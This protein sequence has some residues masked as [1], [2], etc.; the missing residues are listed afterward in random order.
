MINALFAQ[1]LKLNI[2]IGVGAIFTPVGYLIFAFS[3]D[4][5][6]AATGFL[7]ITFALSFANI[8]FLTFYQNNVPVEIMG[9]FSS[10]F[11]IFEALLIIVFTATIGLFA[12]QFNIRV[13]YIIGSFAFF[14]LG[15]VINMIVANK[16]KRKY[17]NHGVVE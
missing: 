15:V 8:G 13:I 17:Y 2:L 11:G 6:W 14:F 9:R 10:V 3:Y 16:S 12:E 1:Y 7:I 4:F 5:I